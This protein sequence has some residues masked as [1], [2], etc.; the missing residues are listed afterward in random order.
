MATSIKSKF[1]QEALENL[2]KNFEMD[3]LEAINTLLK[4]KIKCNSMM[5]KDLEL[6]KNCF[7]CKVKN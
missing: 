5:K 1:K 2:K 7:V 4:G 6:F 3:E